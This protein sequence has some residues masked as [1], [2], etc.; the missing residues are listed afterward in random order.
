MLNLPSSTC[1]SH[2]P[3]GAGVPPPG[4]HPQDQHRAGQ[5]RLQLP[6]GRDG[7]GALQEEHSGLHLPV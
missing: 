2:F 5:L 6:A 4:L 7:A 3:G 1:L